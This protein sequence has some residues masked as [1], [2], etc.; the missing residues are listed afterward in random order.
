MTTRFS[1]FYSEEQTCG[2]RGVSISDF[3]GWC[4]IVSHNDG[5]IHSPSTPQQY[6]SDKTGVCLGG[7]KMRTVS[8]MKPSSGTPS[9]AAGVALR[10]KKWSNGTSVLKT[11]VAITSCSPSSPSFVPGPLWA[12]WAMFLVESFALQSQRSISEVPWQE[13]W[14]GPVPA[15]THQVAL[16]RSLLPGEWGKGIGLDS[17]WGP[18][19]LQE[20]WLN[21]PAAFAPAWQHQP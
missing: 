18:F 2:T 10:N 8:T 5:P 15:P 13:P 17:L 4:L 12:I 19:H 14:G 21:L 6:L 7:S 20:A 1:R 11:Q 3:Y 16:G 9:L